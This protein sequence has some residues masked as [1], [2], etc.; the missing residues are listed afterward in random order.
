MFS[1]RKSSQFTNGSVMSKH[2]KAKMYCTKPKQNSGQ[3]VEQ[4]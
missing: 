2:G 1:E 3:F 4:G